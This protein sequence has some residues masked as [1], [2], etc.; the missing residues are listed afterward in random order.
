MARDPLSL[1][2][3]PEKRPFFYRDSG[4]DM[5]FFVVL[6]IILVVGLATLY[7]ASHV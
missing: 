3:R 6:S 2:R 1:P 4:F 7:S 5:F